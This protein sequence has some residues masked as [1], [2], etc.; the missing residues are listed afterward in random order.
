MKLTFLG[1]GAAFVTD[2]NNF[3]SNMLLETT[4]GELL[5]IDC[6]GDARRSLHARGLNH[7]DIT[8][9]YI[10]HLH[11]DHAGG[12]EWLAFS[13]KFDKNCATKPKLYLHEDLVLPLWNHTLAGGLTSLSDEPSSLQAYFEVNSIPEGQIFNWQ[14]IPFQIIKNKH[15]HSHF[16]EMPSYGLF[17]PLN[18]QWILLTTDA[19]FQLDHFKSYYQKA[20]IIFHDCETSSKRSGVHAHYQD[21]KTLDPNIKAKMWLY[22]YNCNELPNAKAD[23]FLGFV[24]PGQRFTF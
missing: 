14:G 3:H 19:Q 4:S 21:L 8:N 12:L 6:G 10:S 11:A 9:V 5:L 13:R 7:Q 24:Q 18:N 16:A 23:G 1:A 2:P 20:D 15:I 17:F 22:H